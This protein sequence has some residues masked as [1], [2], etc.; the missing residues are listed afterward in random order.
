MVSAAGSRVGLVRGM[1][2]AA[3]NVGSRNV[4]GADDHQKMPRPESYRRHR[5][6]RHRLAGRGDAGLKRAAHERQIGIKGSI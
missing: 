4:Y 5:S 6:G 2:A 1:E 3:V